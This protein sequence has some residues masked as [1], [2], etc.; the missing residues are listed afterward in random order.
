MS[1][2]LLTALVALCFLAVAC[3]SDDPQDG[4]LPEDTQT[5]QII[6]SEDTEDTGDAAVEDTAAEPTPT[7]APQ[8]VV[9]SPYELVTG[10]CFNEYILVDAN[11]VRQEVTTA[12]D[13]NLAHDGEVYFHLFF[14]GDAN[15]AFPGESRLD[16]WSQEQC[17]M[18]FESFVGQ[19]Y[20]LSELD[21]GMILPT[22]ET[23]TGAGLHRQVTCYVQP[24]QGGQLQGSMRGT[25]Y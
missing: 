1:I 22:L 20:E 8:G 10:D 14:P 4:A 16:E 17:F 24:W 7:P 5:P 15:T 19:S 11:E 21:I 18:Q 3:S 25:G 12:L 13:C 23:W 6:G 9:V 2:R